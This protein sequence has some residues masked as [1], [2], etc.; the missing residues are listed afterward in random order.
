MRKKTFKEVTGYT[1]RE[2]IKYIKRLR[3]EN[4]G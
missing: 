2:K 1:I 4:G 3:I